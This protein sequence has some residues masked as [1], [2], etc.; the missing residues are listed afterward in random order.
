M[1]LLDHRLNFICGL[2]V[3][4]LPLYRRCLLPVHLTAAGQSQ[5]ATQPGNG[6]NLWKTDA[7]QDAANEKVA[8]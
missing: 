6:V 5:P 7:P 4:H 2:G 8:L 3:L 1:V